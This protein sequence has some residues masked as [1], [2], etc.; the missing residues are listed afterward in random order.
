MRFQHSLIVNISLMD[1][2]L[3]LIFGKQI[4]MN[5]KKL[6]KRVFWKKF[7]ETNG[8]FWAQ[9]WCVLITLVLPYGFY[10]LLS[11]AKNHDKILLL[12]FDPEYI[13]VNESGLK[14]MVEIRQESVFSWPGR[15]LRAKNVPV[16]ANRTE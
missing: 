1:W 7:F 10:T 13:K 9:K 3:T 5:E 6:Y 11:R 12:N 8:P 4:D 16:F 15:I 14:E 2:H